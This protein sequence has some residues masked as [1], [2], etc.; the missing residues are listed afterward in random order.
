V[1]RR[2]LGRAGRS[3][4][5]IVIAATAATGCGGDEG[6]TASF[7]AEVAEVPALES[8]LA[9]FSEADPQVLQDRI[10]RARSA[11]EDLAE[12]APGSI[13]AETDEV[14]ELV[15]EVLAAVEDHPNDPAAAADQLRVVMAEHEGVD[16]ARREVA[17]FAQE[18]CDL[19]LDPTLGSSTEEVTTT[20]GA[21]TS[22]TSAADDVTTTVG[23]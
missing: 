1:A 17:S 8:V 19:R 12:A 5:A 10:D 20:T 4:V 3:I 2:R 22:S 6:S 18:E 15:D 9:R 11:Y 23:G 16:A 7:C 13:S 14:V 21:S